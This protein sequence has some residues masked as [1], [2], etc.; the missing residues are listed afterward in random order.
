MSAFGGIVLFGTGSSPAVSG[1]LGADVTSNPLY[2]KD[3]SGSSHQ[4]VWGAGATGQFNVQ[5]SNDFDPNGSPG[6]GH[7]ETFTLSTAD[8]AL[9]APAGTADDGG[10][11]IWHRCD[12]VREVYDFASGTG[13]GHGIAES[14]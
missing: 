5:W 7:W 6:N 2:V 3:K 10:V 8:A 11:Q 9:I 14:F 13:T 1:S 12:W 4:F